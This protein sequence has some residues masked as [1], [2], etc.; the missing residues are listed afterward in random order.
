MGSVS[1]R[2]TLDRS[3]NPSE[4]RF[5]HLHSGMMVQVRCEDQV[6]AKADLWA[7]SFYKY[8]WSPRGAWRLL[9][10]L[11]VTSL[12]AGLSLTFAGPEKENTWRSQPPAS[13]PPLP[14][15]DSIHPC[16][17][18]ASESPGGFVKAQMAES[19]PQSFWFICISSRVPGNINTAGPGPTRHFTN[20][21]PAS[22][23][24]WVCPKPLED[25]GQ[26]PLSPCWGL[27]PWGWSSQ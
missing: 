27:A 6:G 15:P 11:I 4:S 2:V 26:W 8:L 1:G 5:P 23:R 19:Q 13:P 9:S 3:P 10:G 24:S 25:S 12:H 7:H 21:L 22:S 16:K 20:H 17:A 14:T 18:R